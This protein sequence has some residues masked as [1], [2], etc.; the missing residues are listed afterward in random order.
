MLSVIQSFTFLVL[1]ATAWVAQARNIAR[2]SPHTSNI[3]GGTVFAPDWATCAN[4]DSLK[5]PFGNTA[6]IAVRPDCD[7]A[8]DVV[9]KVAVSDYSKGRQMRNLKAT[10]GA[11][12]SCE[13]NIL[14]SQP[15]LADALDYDSC[16]KSFQGITTLCLLLGDAPY[17][18]PAQQAGVTNVIYTQDGG[19]GN[20]TYPKMMASNLYN[21][22]PGY[23]VGPP[24][25]FGGVSYGTDVTGTYG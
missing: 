17:A 16:V 6:S 7:A 18:S 21:L 5:Q 14:F 9:C 15:K 12:S 19:P 25:Y 20:S 24:N 2:G 22:K 23:M 8:I 4:D 1:L 10:S 11:G 3:P 13:A